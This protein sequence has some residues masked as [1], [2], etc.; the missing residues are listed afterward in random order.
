[1]PNA[2]PRNERRSKRVRAARNRTGARTAVQ[3][4]EVEKLFGLYDYRLAPSL[5]AETRPERLLVLYGDNGSG[6]TTLLKTLVHVLSPANDEGHRSALAQI[7]F[8]RFSV[9]LTNH[10][11]VEVFRR[12]P[13]LIGEYWYRLTH[14]NGKRSEARIPVSETKQGVTV[15]FGSKGLERKW[16]AVRRDIAKLGV[17]LYF[18]S[19]DRKASGQSVAKE[20]VVAEA[21]QIFDV[22]SGEWKVA[23]APAQPKSALDLALER[24]ESWARNE[25]LRAS[26]VGEADSNKIYADIARRIATSRGSQKSEPGKIEKLRQSL[27]EVAA[28]NKSFATLGLVSPLN[29]DEIQTS[30]EVLSP[31]RRGVMANVLGPY[32]EGVLAR[33]NAL[34]NVQEVINGFLAAV[35]QFLSAKRVTF[36]VARGIGIASST[37]EA[38]EPEMLSSGEKQILLLFCNTITA[39]HH[40][41]IFIID[42][43][44][45]SLNVKWQRKLLPALLEMTQ[46]SFVQFIVATHSIALLAPYKHNVLA[47]HAG[48]LGAD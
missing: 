23:A 16:E 13:L 46:E 18:L 30:I 1:M 42:E 9:S 36:D 43:P 2:N 39:R 10:A 15:S 19:D 26:S 29:L 7:R 37:G 11:R 14:A 40:S 47:L 31:S 33:L 45:I 25:A 8:R 35:N 27:A 24:T 48:E 17:S 38:L 41:S 32:V 22:A 4:I 3:S 34:Q 21:T 5:N 44:E 12:S 6:K 28:R 20:R